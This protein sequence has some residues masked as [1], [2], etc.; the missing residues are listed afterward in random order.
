MPAGNRGKQFIIGEKES[1]TKPELGVAVD[2]RECI[3]PTH[4]PIEDG[5]NI[6]SSSI[7]S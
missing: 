7:S 3:W 5:Y 2:G 6:D 1:R 4:G